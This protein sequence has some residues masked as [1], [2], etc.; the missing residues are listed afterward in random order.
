LQGLCFTTS[1]IRQSEPFQTGV[2]NVHETG[3]SVNVAH[4]LMDVGRLSR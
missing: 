2:S 4:N 1:Y 3:T